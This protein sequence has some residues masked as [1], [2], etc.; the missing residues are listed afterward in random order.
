MVNIKDFF[1]IVREISLPQIKP[2]GYDIIN[3]PEYR[4]SRE[5][6][7]RKPL[8]ADLF[9]FIEY[10][11]LSRNSPQGF[12]I[13]MFR[14]LGG[15]PIFN[16]PPDYPKEGIWEIMTIPFLLSTYLKLEI[17][18]YPETGIWEFNTTEELRKQISLG[19]DLINKYGLGWVEK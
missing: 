13:I 19:T 4:K 5:L 2:N 11:L 1:S 6:F 8:G 15:K 16:P 10:Q 12:Q 18:N 7:F 9:G 14:N 17:S 3:I